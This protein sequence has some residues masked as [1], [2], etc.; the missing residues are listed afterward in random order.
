MRLLPSQQGSPGA[1][2]CPSASSGCPSRSSLSSHC[3]GLPWGCR[4]W[5]G[6]VPRG[7]RHFR[8]CTWLWGTWLSHPTTRGSVWEGQAGTAALV[9]TPKNV[10]CLSPGLGHRHEV[11]FLWEMFPVFPTHG[12]HRTLTSRPD[13]GLLRCIPWPFWSKGLFLFSFWFCCFLVFVF[14]FLINSHVWQ[15]YL[16]Y[17]G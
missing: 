17:K 8:L 10:T 11:A 4:G 5:V 2:S 15:Q 6:A 12:A 9:N 1:P 3:H 7:H 16:F 13:L 14:F